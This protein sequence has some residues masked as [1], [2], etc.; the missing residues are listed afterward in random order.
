MANEKKALISSNSLRLI[1]KPIPS[2][3][4]VK[5]IPPA[6]YCEIFDEN[7]KLT[8]FTFDKYGG[9][10]TIGPKGEVSVDLAHFKLR[11]PM[12]EFTIDFEWD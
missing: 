1:C 9:S 8:S 10:L 6:I 3:E 5:G 11:A 4:L 12:R 2:K 7:K